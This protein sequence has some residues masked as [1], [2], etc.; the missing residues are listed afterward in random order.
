MGR[1][2]FVDHARGQ[3]EQFVPA[4]DLDRLAER[5]CEA[6]ERSPGW[7][8][9]VE[10]LFLID[11]EPY[12]IEG[13]EPSALTVC[14]RGAEYEVFYYDGPMAETITDHPSWGNCL[15]RPAERSA[16]PDRPGERRPLRA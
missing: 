7:R 16:E 8:P 2:R 15:D 1:V 14:H 5:A 4:A 6:A 3:V 10:F 13:L 9:G 12:T 11:E